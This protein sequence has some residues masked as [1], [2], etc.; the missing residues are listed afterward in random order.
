MPVILSINST[1][2]A[3][4]SLTTCWRCHGCCSGLSKM[5]PLMLTCLFPASTSHFSPCSFPVPITS[6]L[7]TI[8]RDCRPAVLA[9]MQR[10]V[11]ICYQNSAPQSVVLQALPNEVQAS[12]STAW[13]HS[14]PWDQGNVH[15]KNNCTI[16]SHAMHFASW[17]D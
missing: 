14:Q 4:S 12:V 5:L 13:L 17:L 2:S 16:N 3:T 15:R 7:R 1:T 10:V 11:G 9:F 6:H 8:K